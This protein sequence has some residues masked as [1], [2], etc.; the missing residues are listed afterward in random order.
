MRQLSRLTAILFMVIFLTGCDKDDS[1]SAS[2]SM[3]KDPNTA[4]KASV[5]R[6][7]SAA[8]VLFVRDNSNGLP[9]ANAPINMDIV[10]FIAQGFGPNGGIV[11]YYNFDV[12]STTPAPIYVLFKQ[13]ESTPVAGQLNIIDVL[14]GET[15]YND[16]WQVHQVTVPATY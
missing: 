15:G 3:V 7:S 14:P 4:P 16:F 6:F 12:Q 9:A 10:P 11:R 2:S 1:P 8:G 5:D 13:G